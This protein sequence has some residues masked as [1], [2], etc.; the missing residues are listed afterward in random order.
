MDSEDNPIELKALS[1][2]PD[3]KAKIKF[4]IGPAAA[5]FII[6][7]R[8]FLKNRL[9]TGTGLAHPKPTKSIIKDPIGSK[10]AMGF[11]DSLPILAAVLSPHLCAI[12]ACAY[13]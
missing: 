10:C 6:S 9:S 5:T 4:D 12:Q 2:M 1:I 7:V 8:G 13:S 11:K 3:T